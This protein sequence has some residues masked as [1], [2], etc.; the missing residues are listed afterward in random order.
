M[1]WRY[2]VS[3]RWRSPGEALHKE[4][5]RDA[6]AAVSQVQLIRCVIEI[7][8]RWRDC[9]D[10]VSEPHGGVVCCDVSQTL[11]KDLM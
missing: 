10:P 3:D 9:N 4:I 11:A 1:S 8:P 2:R 6:P 5:Q 7:L